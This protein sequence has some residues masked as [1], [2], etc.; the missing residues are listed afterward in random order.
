MQADQVESPRGRGVGDSDADLL[1]YMAMTADDPD[2]ARAAWEAFYRRHAQYLHAVCLRAYGPLLGGDAGAADLVAETFQRAYE[3]AGTFDAAGIDD[4]ERLRLRARA[5]L[6]RIA[7][8]LAQTTLRGRGRLRTRFL[9]QDAWQQVA[10][11]PDRGGADAETI[12]RVRRAIESLNEK[13]QAVLRVTFQWYQPERDHQRLPN[14]VAADLAAS[15]GTTPENLRQIR[16]RALR[17]IETLL[18][19]EG[20]AP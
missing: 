20:E 7:Q 19:M 17:K 14:D 4:G 2:G 15:L 10:R 12:G 3:R 9:D 6:G 18:R 8:R 5:W 11:E 16:R 13:E 1:A